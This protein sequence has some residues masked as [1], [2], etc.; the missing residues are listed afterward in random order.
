MSNPNLK[1]LVTVLTFAMR[2]GRDAER[3]C[4]SIQ[5]HIF[6]STLLSQPKELGVSNVHPSVF[7]SVRPQ[8][9]SSILMKFGT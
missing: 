8:K 4:M 5:L 2:M 9:V 1:P 7:M 6:R 3:V